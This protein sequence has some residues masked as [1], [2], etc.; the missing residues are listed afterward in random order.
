MRYEKEPKFITHTN[1]KP[2]ALLNSK[3][4]F[5]CAINLFFYFWRRLTFAEANAVSAERIIPFEAAFIAYYTARAAL[6]AA[7]ESEDHVSVFVNL[8]IFHRADRYAIFFGAIF[9]YFRFYFDMRLSRIDLEFSK[10]YL[11]FYGQFFHLI[12][13][14]L[15]HA[16]AGN[17]T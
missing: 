16:A 5:S 8:V 11:V 14:G 12:P 13:P 6:E 2:F 10:A 15:S 7:F 4:F 9:A 1:E 17:F 3:G